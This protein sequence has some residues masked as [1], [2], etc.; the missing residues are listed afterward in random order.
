M[1]GI[2]SFTP[3]MEKSDWESHLTPPPLW[4]VQ[5]APYKRGVARQCGCIQ[6][7]AA[8]HIW[9][10]VEKVHSTVSMKPQ[11]TEN[12]SQSNIQICSASTLQ[13]RGGTAMVADGAKP[14]STFGTGME[15]EEWGE[16]KVVVNIQVEALTCQSEHVF[17]W[18]R[19]L[20]RSHVSLSDKMMWSSNVVTKL[21]LGLKVGRWLVK[22]SM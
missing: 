9:S 5:P 20:S 11:T 1:W 8:F 15:K 2:P 18:D 22:N 12:Q 17:T 19:D 16:R 3:E 6:S 7:Q 13:T 14:L 10:Q 4:F 21:A